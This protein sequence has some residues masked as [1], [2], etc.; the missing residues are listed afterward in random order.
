MQIHGEYTSA[1]KR[2]KPS[3]EIWNKERVHYQMIGMKRNI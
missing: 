2:W 1:N 3:Q